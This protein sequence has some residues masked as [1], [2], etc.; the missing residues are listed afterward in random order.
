V[1][2]IAVWARIGDSFLQWSEDSIMRMSWFD[3]GEA[4]PV[5]VT[6]TGIGVW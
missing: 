1:R 2:V 6:T 3:N 5:A 4:V